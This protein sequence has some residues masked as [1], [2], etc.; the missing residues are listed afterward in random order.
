MKILRTIAPLRRLSRAAVGP[1][2][3]VP[4]MGALHA[5]H[6]ALIDRARQL[7]GRAGTVIVSIFVNHEELARSPRPFPAERRVCAAHGADVIF[8][9]DV[10]E[11]Y[12]PDFSTFVEE[13]EVSDPLCGASR[14][15]HFRGV[16][17]VVLKLL[18]AAEPDLAVFGLKDYQQC[19]VLRRMVRDFALPVGL[20]FIPTLRA[21]DG[22]ALSSRNA[23]LDPA[24]RQQAPA[25]RRGLLRAAELHRSGEKSAAALRRVVL[26]EIA[27]APLARLDYVEVVDATS[28]RAV[29]KVAAP[30]VIAAAVF[31]GRTRLI[32]NE[33]IALQSHPAPF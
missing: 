10:A 32:D 31:F 1:V 25:L 9:P 12:P 19:A 15:G 26:R 22:L 11:M 20:D 14:P 3:L 13:R 27:K 8:H 5:G 6:A 30:A 33:L 16:C 23:Y 21:A 17:T 18:L 28:L 7:A 29:R 2:V 4:T 24:Q